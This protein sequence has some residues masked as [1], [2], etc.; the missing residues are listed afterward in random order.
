[1]Y[2][3]WSKLELS[4]LEIWI[5]LAAHS[6]I[7]QLHQPHLLMEFLHSFARAF[8]T[9]VG[10]LACISL[11]QTGP[12]LFILCDVCVKTTYNMMSTQISPPPKKQQQQQQNTKTT[13]TKKLKA[14]S[15]H[16]SVTTNTGNTRK[17]LVAGWP[18]CWNVNQVARA[19]L[20]VK[21]G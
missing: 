5:T 13:T 18:T 2:S 14:V 20:L 7:T 6:C 3:L 9:A 4:H 1:M 15:T 11:H 8:F 19:R 16:I 17:Y 10:S 12:Q 21:A